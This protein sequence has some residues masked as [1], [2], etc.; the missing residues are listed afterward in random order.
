MDI[1]ICGLLNLLNVFKELKPF[2]YDEL[3]K[4][5]QKTMNENFGGKIEDHIFEATRMRMVDE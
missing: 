4:Q 5:M 2:M 3:H 1:Q